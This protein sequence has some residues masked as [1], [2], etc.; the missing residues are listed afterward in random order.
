MCKSKSKK[1]K[2]ILPGSGG[3]EAE[4]DGAQHD[5]KWAPT[6]TELA[7]GGSLSPPTMCGRWL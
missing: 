6:V 4:R 3:A 2:K 7:G 1:K 5:G